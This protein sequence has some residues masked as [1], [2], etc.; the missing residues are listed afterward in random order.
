[1]QLERRS[2][3]R[4]AGVTI[5]LPLLEALAPKRARAAVTSGVPHR[6]VC[7]CAPL[8]FYPPNFFP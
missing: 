4:A 8:G 7:I 2:F 1:M 5:T 3:L 6:M